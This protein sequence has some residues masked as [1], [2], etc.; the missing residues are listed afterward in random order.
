[1]YTV[2]WIAKRSSHA[3]VRVLENIGKLKAVSAG[4]GVFMGNTRLLKWS[5]KRNCCT[6]RTSLNDR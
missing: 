6:D 3:L 4:W 2:G 5:R 1:M